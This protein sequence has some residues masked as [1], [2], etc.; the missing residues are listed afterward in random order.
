MRKVAF[1]PLSAVALAILAGCVDEKIVYQNRELFEEPLSAANGFLGYTST[2][3]KLT[4]CGNCH[5][6]TQGE[7]EETAHADAWNGLQDSGHA[8][9]FC[10]GCHT[11]NEL[12]NIVTE[13]S[14]HSATGEERYYDVQCES[15]HGP[16][17]AHVVDPQDATVPLAPMEVGLDLTQ[18]CAECHQGNHHPFAEEWTASAHGTVNAYPAGRAACEGCHTGEGALKM[19]GVNTVFL[20]QDDVSQPG[21]HLA[22]TCAVCHDPHGSDHS[23]QLRFPIDEPSEDINLCMQCHHKRGT[24]DPS[25]FRGPHSPEGPTLLGTAGW[26]PPGL[27]QP[28][29]STHGSED[30]NPRL[31]AGCHV[32]SYE[33]NDL[34]TG[35][36][37]FNAT[38]HRFEATPCTD[39]QGL[40]VEGPCPNSEK[41]YA[42]CTDCHS[43]AVA[44]QLV[45][46][47]ELSIEADV[48]ELQDLLNTVETN[49]PG[50]FDQD[51]NRYTVA[52][53]SRFNL[54]LAL[55]PGAV[56]HNPFLIRA[57]LDASIAEMK[58]EYNLP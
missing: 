22:I 30:E 11:V 31:C 52:E 44:L 35:E 1:L 25:T 29:I 16:G 21:E 18:G 54:E 46:Q 39:A 53:G 9:A 24:P 4:V 23:G 10:E 12:G 27:A 26:W 38:G 47:A 19:F 13:V 8:Q 28:I 56:V 33:I 48:A 3:D 6:G 2:E 40:L 17:L 43:E 20:E 49:M 36:F 15:C 41:T 58:E 42:A 34:E 51:D 45:N 57:L 32:N 7:W 50:E 55:T 5:V 14:G 37:L